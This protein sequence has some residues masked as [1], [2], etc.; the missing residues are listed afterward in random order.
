MCA[1]SVEGMAA[2]EQEDSGVI[3]RVACSRRRR[4]RS[5]RFYKNHP[6]KSSDSAKVQSAW[7]DN[8]FMSGVQ[9]TGKPN[10]TPSKAKLKV[11]LKVKSPA[12]HRSNGTSTPKQVNIN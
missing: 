6:I 3:R 7:I 8:S 4:R 10:K 11:N 2:I 9:N 5:E 1:R 12:L